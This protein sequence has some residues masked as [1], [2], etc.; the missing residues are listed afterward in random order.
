MN[1]EKPQTLE[2]QVL[3]KPQVLEIKSG[4]L[5]AIRQWLFPAEFRIA[6]PPQAAVGLDTTEGLDEARGGREPGAER[7]G[8]DSNLVVAEVATCLWY[9]KTKYFKRAWPDAEVSD[10]D[11][12]VRRALSRLNKCIGLLKDSGIEVHDPV[13]ERY[14]YGGTSTMRLIEHVPTAGITVERVSE[15][16]A[17]MVHCDGQLIQRAEVFVS[18][19]KDEP[20]P[21]SA[22]GPAASST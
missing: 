11:P 2:K 14:P 20:G 9:L 22:S 17:P 16:V 4:P 21:H 19:P 12:K 6:A 3:E 18:V 7:A 8:P 5:D 13:N 15:T 10:D 1:D